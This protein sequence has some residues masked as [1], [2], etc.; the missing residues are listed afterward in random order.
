MSAKRSAEEDVTADHKRHKTMSMHSEG[1]SD[2]EVHLD[3]DL[4]SRQIAVYGREVM[5]RMAGASILISGAN[6]LGVEIGGCWHSC[7]SVLGTLLFS[8][9]SEFEPPKPRVAHPSPAAKNVILAGVKAVTVHDTKAV[10]LRSLGAQFYL[11]EK[12]VGKNRAE[13]CREKLHELNKAVAVASST[14]AVLEG[15]F[16]LK[17]SVSPCTPCAQRTEC[18]C[19]RIPVLHTLHC[20]DLLSKPCCSSF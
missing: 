9:I 12:D 2:G 13:A 8:K 19:S 14:A 18:L 20:M 3:E 17:F 5:K 11:T 4:H 15:G 16:L 10:E 6:G 7:G 1:P